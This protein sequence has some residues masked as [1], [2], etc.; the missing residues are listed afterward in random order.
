MSLEDQQQYWVALLR[1]MKK[2]ELLRAL[3][4]WVR[5]PPGQ[6]RLR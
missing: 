3:C 4:K 5:T 1:Y 2:D 6:N